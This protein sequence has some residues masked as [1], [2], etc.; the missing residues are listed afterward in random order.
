[1]EANY[2]NVAQ[3]VSSKKEKTVTP[4]HH[5][6][7]PPEI[8][9][10]M[11]KSRLLSLSPYTNL[12]NWYPYKFMLLSTKINC[13]MVFEDHYS[14]TIELFLKVDLRFKRLLKLF[15]VDLSQ[16]NPAFTKKKVK[17]QIHTLDFFKILN[18]KYSQ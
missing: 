7:S 1:M 6:H 14:K 17:T 2:W 8:T 10:Y 4:H 13:Y 3:K 15:N 11:V 9:F 16:A 5:I 12:S 18:L